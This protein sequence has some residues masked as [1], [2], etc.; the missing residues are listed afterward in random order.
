MSNEE[1]LKTINDI[2]IAVNQLS[3]SGIQ[4]CNIISFIGVNLNKI[5]EELKPAENDNDYKIA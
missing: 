5:Y 4:N 1:I 3:V 2:K